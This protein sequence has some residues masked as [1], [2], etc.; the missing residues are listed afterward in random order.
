VSDI[1]LTDEKWAL[2]ES[3]LPGK[4]GDPG[5][6][7]RDNRL[8]IEGVLWIART[9]SPWRQLPV[10]YGKWYTTYVRFHR[11]TKRNVWPRVFARLALESD[12]PFLYQHGKIHYASSPTTFDARESPLERPIVAERAA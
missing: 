9:G 10:E 3:C 7:G 11:W 6:H 5:C 4:Q 12:W 2:I 8:F 1:Y